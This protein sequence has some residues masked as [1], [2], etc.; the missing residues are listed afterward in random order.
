[1]EQEKVNLVIPTIEMQILA[2]EKRAIGDCDK[3]L[4]AHFKPSMEAK[5]LAS[6][7]FH[8]LNQG[9]NSKLGYRPAPELEEPP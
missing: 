5:P 3:L 4:A 9:S 1:M 7:A 6:A 2:Q 8:H